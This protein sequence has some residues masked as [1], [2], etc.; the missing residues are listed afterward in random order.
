MKLIE[1]LSGGRCT[2]IPELCIAL[3]TLF[4]IALSSTMGYVFITQEILK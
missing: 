1:Y 3:Q 2:D 4:V